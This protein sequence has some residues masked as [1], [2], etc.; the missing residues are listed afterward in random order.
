M[1][2]NLNV[3]SFVFERDL[4]ALLM[5]I[6]EFKGSWKAYGNL[7]PARL[8]ELKRI[9]TIESIGSSTRIEGANLSDAEV[10]RIMAGLSTQSFR[11][12]DE[13]EVAGYALLMNEIFESWEE[14]PLTENII[15]QMHSLLMRKSDKDERHRGEYKHVENNVAAFDREGRQIGVV[16]ETASAFETP[17]LME[18]LVQ[19]T[20]LEL[21]GNRLPALIIIGMFVVIFLAIHPFEDGNGRLSRALTVLLLLRAGYVYA[22]YS[23]L[24][25]VIEGS[26]ESYYIALRAT[27]RTLGNEDPDWNVWMRYFLKAL[28]KQVRS[29]KVK[30]EGEHLL[31]TMP[32]IS[33]RIIELLKE[34][35]SLGI[36]DAER[37]LS[38]NKYTLRAHFKNLTSDGYLIKIGKGPATKYALAAYSAEEIGR[39]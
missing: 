38:I 21:S 16:F 31:K 29:L 33:L 9:A 3:Q 28:V 19:W 37:L 7:A 6:E 22:P 5:E 30:I 1:H 26:K 8:T 13:Q 36:A 17:R 15:R 2:L 24:E 4:V 20:N 14:M 12:R 34:H 35:G 27:Q 25:S 23:S 10:A 32:E 11:T 18:E 39:H